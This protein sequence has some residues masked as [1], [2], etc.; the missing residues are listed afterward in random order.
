MSKIYAKLRDSKDRAQ[1]PFFLQPC[2]PPKLER[3]TQCEARGF[4]PE[5]HNFGGVGKRSLCTIGTIFIG[6]AGVQGKMSIN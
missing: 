6:R 5:G 2:D 4:E 1:S 3:N